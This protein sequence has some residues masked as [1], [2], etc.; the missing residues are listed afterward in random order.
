MRYASPRLGAPAGQRTRS[1]SA[2]HVFWS[3]RCRRWISPVSL[4]YSLCG[5]EK[6]GLSR[7]AHNAENAPKWFKSRLRNLLETASGRSQSC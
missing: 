3:A 6:P 5:V 2:S 7:S 1:L 4:I